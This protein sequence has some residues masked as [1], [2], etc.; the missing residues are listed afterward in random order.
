M[1]GIQF[2][3]DEK[4]RNVAVPRIWP[5]AGEHYDVTVRASILPARCPNY[6]RIQPIM[7]ASSRDSRACRCLRPLGGGCRTRSSYGSRLEALPSDTDSS[8]PSSYAAGHPS[9]P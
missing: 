9:E 6:D 8:V 2:V 7:T 3:T 5:E 1:T 4:G